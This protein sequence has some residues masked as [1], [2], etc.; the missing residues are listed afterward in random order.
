LLCRKN[1]DEARTL[2]HQQLYQ[3]VAIIHEH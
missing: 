1:I 2:V 3:F